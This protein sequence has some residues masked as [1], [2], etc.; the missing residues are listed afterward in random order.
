MPSILFLIV[1]VVIYI[2]TNNAQGVSFLHVLSN[3]CNLLSF[4]CSHSNGS[5]MI[6]WFWFS[7]T[8]WLKTLNIFF[9]YLLDICMSS[10]EKIPIQILYPF[11]ISC[12]LF[13]FGFV[14][15]FL[16]V[17][18]PCAEGF[19]GWLSPTCLFLLLLCCLSFGV[20]TKKSLFPRPRS[21]RYFFFFSYN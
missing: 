21:R 1:L 16:C 5:D 18:F 11:L 19:L 20:I 4:G 8:W 2:F 17:C 7:F 10:L 14:C 3:T 15:L 12:F 9:I 6:S 13:C